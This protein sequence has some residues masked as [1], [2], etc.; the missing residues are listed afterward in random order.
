MRLPRLTPT[1]LVLVVV[2]GVLLMH[3]FE[4]V[5]PEPLATHTQHDVDSADVAATVAGTCLFVTELVV[6]AADSPAV[7]FTVIRLVEPQ[8]RLW[9]TR[10]SAEGEHSQS[11]FYE[12][13]VIRV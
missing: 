11:S 7:S 10:G 4:S 2:S 8:T 3:G 13:C 5:S 1:L 9:T 12:R 6:A